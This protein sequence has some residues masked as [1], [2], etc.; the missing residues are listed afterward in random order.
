MNQQD[1]SDPTTQKM[2]LFNKINT[3]QEGGQLNWMFKKV[4]Q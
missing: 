4:I 3:I 2:F 1:M